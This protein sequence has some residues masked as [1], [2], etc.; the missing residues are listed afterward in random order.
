MAA[1]VHAQTEARL[2]VALGRGRDGERA[3]YD[4]PA[5][6]TPGSVWGTEVY[7]DDSAACAAGVHAGVITVAEGGRVTIEIR[8]GENAYVGSTQN[9]IES[10]DWESWSGSFVV[11]GADG[12]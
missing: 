10:L 11:I 1:R 12:G 4:C 6:G 5:G 9:G 3:V 7:T 2:A 8:Q